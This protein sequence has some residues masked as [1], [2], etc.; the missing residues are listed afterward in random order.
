[1]SVPRAQ[2]PHLQ[3]LHVHQKSIS[4]VT[5]CCT[6][7]HVFRINSPRTGSTVQNKDSH[8]RTQRPWQGQCRRPHKSCLDADACLGP[9]MSPCGINANEEDGWPLA[10]PQP[11]PTLPGS[12]R[13]AGE[14][15]RLG[16]AP[17]WGGVSSAEPG[18]RLSAVSERK[19]TALC[20]CST[21][22]QQD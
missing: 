10:K 4:V 3:P 2:S 19:H 21:N 9:E 18:S 8:W 17:G 13:E 15:V 14:G 1:M 20:F 7:H 16:P 22:V 6:Q 5:R 12:R 11:G